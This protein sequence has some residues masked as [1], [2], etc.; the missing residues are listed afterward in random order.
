M[1]ICRNFNLILAEKWGYNEQK[2]K[3]DVDGFKVRLDRFVED[4][5]EIEDYCFSTHVAN[6][7]KTNI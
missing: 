3:K 4:D 2:R 7:W 5:S 6:F 1:N